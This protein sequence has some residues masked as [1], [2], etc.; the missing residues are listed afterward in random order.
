[1]AQMAQGARSP[2]IEMGQASTLIGLVC[3]G[4]LV[5]WLRRVAVEGVVELLQAS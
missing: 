3:Q 1:M 4:L 2:M 5:N